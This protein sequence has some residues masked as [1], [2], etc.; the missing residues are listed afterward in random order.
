MCNQSAACTCTLTVPDVV[1]D[2]LFRLG[3]GIEVI[4]AL[5]RQEADLPTKVK[6]KG[7]PL[8]RS[9]RVNA[10]SYI[11]G[12]TQ[13]LSVAVGQESAMDVWFLSVSYLDSLGSALLKQTGPEARSREL[14]VSCR[15]LVLIACKML[16][17]R[18]AIAFL[19]AKGCILT[20]R[21]DHISPPEVA[22][23]ERFVMTALQHTLTRPTA[24]SWVRIL[25]YRLHAL[26][27]K[28]SS[29]L[30]HQL[31]T[32]VLGQA[33]EILFASCPVPGQV[34]LP[35]QHIIAGLSLLLVFQERPFLSTEEFIWAT[36]LDSAMLQSVALV[37]LRRL[38]AA[39]EFAAELEQEASLN[40]RLHVI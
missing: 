24:S 26:L 30:I 29:L 5:Q 36:G 18:D 40:R 15:A 9:S 6:V 7:L 21:G 39:Q 10:L 22:Q 3:A 27:G 2:Q 1:S 12:M 17:S 13:H 19:K 28:D 4:S 35:S 16:L 11:T 14:L 34:Q 25:Q 32:M 38:A 8:N 37:A 23:K 33:Q 31:G 20:D